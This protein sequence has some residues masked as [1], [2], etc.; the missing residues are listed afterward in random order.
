MLRD[1]EAVQGVP[2]TLM[3]DRQEVGSRRKAKLSHEDL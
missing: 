1:L 3:Q 2:S